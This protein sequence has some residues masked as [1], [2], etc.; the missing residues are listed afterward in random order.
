MK[1]VFHF[2]ILSS[3]VDTEKPEYLSNPTDLTVITG[4]LRLEGVSM[5]TEVILM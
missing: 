1:V 2:Q 5:V 3:I 4:A